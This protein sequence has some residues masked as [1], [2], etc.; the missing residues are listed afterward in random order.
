ML[1]GA[2][3]W[4]LTPQPLD[5]PVGRDR[6]IR[7]EPQHRQHG[8]LLR[9]AERDVV[10]VHAGLD[11]SKDAEPHAAPVF[12]C[13][14]T[15]NPI[16]SSNPGQGFGGQVSRPCQRPL[17]ARST[18]P[19][20]QRQSR[21]RPS[22][23]SVR[24]RPHHRPG[25]HHVH[26]PTHLLPDHRVR[27][28]R[29]RDDQRGR[30]ERVA[31]GPAC[32]RTHATPR[33]ARG[34]FT[35]RD[36]SSPQMFTDRQRAVVTRFKRSPS[37]QQALREAIDGRQTAA[38]RAGP[39][40]RRHRLGRRRHRRREPARRDRPRARGRHDDPAAQA[41]GGAERRLSPDTPSPTSTRTR[42][43][44][45]RPRAAPGTPSGAAHAGKRKPPTNQQSRLMRTNTGR[46]A[47][48]GMG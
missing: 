23:S 27:A 29:A 44:H 6:T 8:A 17:Y 24:G 12:G 16:T 33:R 35:G 41:P 4:L 25:G 21:R 9:A 43:R 38:A 10:A 2:R 32:P 28:A 15:T 22:R 19:T 5:Q 3:R 34:T 48:T 26:R 14:C 42:G 39:R 46:L 31:A 1:R 20:D 36:V 13:S 7:L 37:Y 40:R 47:V 30:R 11:G 18:T 45:V